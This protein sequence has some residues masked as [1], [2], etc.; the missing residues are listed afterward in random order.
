MSSKVKILKMYRNTAYSTHSSVVSAYFRIASLTFTLH[1]KMALWY[2]NV[3][4]F[5]SLES[6]PYNFHVWNCRDQCTRWLLC[7]T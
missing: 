1:L 2:L 3:I 6:A 5:C 4:E 7:P